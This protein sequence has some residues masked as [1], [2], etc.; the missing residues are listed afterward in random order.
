[1]NDTTNEFHGLESVDGRAVVG[2]RIVWHETTASTND[3]A[4]R[5]AEAGEPEGLVV[6][7]D[8]QTAGRGR[9]SRSWISPPGRDLLFSVLLRPDAADLPKMPLLAG[10]AVARTLD[11]FTSQR[12]TLKWPNDVRAAD[13][14]ISGTLAESGHSDAG[15]Y[16]VIGTGVNVNLD[17][18]AHPEIAEIATSLRTLNGRSVSR[19]EVMRRLLKEMDDIYASPGAMSA[20]VSDWSERLE[21]IG[22]EID[23][24]WGDESI[25]G[26]AEGVDDSG[27]LL[28]RD[29]DGVVHRLEAGEVTL[30]TTP[31]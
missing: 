14:K 18:A 11:A 3:D 13:R 27:R 23:V 4:R 2:R 22:Q 12:V 16:A 25:H 6:I 24:L 9:M 30:Q 19:R 20:L 8:V 5:A 7:A 28:L 15:Y 21:T 1:M 26:V 29:R 17:A 31:R 10:L